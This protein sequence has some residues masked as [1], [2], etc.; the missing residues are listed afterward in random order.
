MTSARC[1]P[2]MRERPYLKEPPP[3][4]E[5]IRPESGSGRAA[6]RLRVGV[7]VVS[8]SGGEVNALAPTLSPSFIPV[9][10]LLLRQMRNEVQK[11][12]SLS[13]GVAP[14]L[15]RGIGFI[16]YGGAFMCREKR[17]GRVRFIPSG[18]GGKGEG[19][20]SIILE[21][22]LQ[23]RV[24]HDV[25]AVFHSHL[26]HRARLIHLDGLDADVEAGGYLLVRV[27]PGEEA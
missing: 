17:R 25:D 7:D 9:F 11:R 19:I 16:S 23:E 8:E 10:V 6:S 1:G 5:L 20:R 4:S 27:A 13:R 15:L 2:G 18:G 14:N 12:D 3:Q 21:P 22:A 24:A 26:L